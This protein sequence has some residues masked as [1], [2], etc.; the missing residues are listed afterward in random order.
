MN[1]V[2]AQA[3]LIL[4]Y[5]GDTAARYEPAPEFMQCAPCFWPKQPE[6]WAT[7][8]SRGSPGIRRIT[9][10]VNVHVQE[11]HTGL[12]SASRS[13]LSKVAFRVN[14]EA[15]GGWGRLKHAGIYDSQNKWPCTAV[16]SN[17]QNISQ[18]H[19]HNRLINDQIAEVVGRVWELD[20]GTCAVPLI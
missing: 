14:E 17:T 4:R 7:H 1:K 6:T 19:T 2:A 15:G 9:S 20:A 5:H 13:S 8:P 12:F 3:A 16:V 11:S 10:R 18:S